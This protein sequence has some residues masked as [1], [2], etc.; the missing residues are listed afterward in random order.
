MRI[1][2]FVTARGSGTQACLRVRLW[3]SRWV[4]RPQPRRYRGPAQPQRRWREAPRV[5]R[6]GYSDTFDAF[7]GIRTWI[8]PIAS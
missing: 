6:V 2:V 3:R 8:G 4:R 5:K 1:A 7:A